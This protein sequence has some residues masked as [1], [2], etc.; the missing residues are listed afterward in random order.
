MQLA[1]SHQRCIGAIL[2]QQLTTQ[3]VYLFGSR[4]TQTAQKFSDVDICLVGEAL[5]FTQMLALKELFSDSDLPYFV[6]IVQKS[7]LS[8]SFY[9]ALQKD[10]IEMVWWAG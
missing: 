3:K 9:K 10:F 1:E 7:D 8:E 4:A 2:R 6:D 5:S